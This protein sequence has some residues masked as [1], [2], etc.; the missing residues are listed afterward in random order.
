MSLHDWDLPDNSV[1]GEQ[2]EPSGRWAIQHKAFREYAVAASF[3][4]LRLNR[5]AQPRAQLG[6]VRPQVANA[7]YRRIQPV[8]RPVDD[9]RRLAFAPRIREFLPGERL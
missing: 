2:E 7:A 1:A 8:R 3:P 5:P 9:T 4:M 6:I